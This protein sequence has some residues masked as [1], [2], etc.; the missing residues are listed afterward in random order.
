MSGI[1][2]TSINPNAT[3]VFL[4]QRN[5]WFKIGKWGRVVNGK[6]TR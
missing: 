3:L 4:S 5:I 1:G 2:D 6:K